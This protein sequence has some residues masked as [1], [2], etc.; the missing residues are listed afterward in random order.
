MELELVIVIVGSFITLG[1]SINAF[2]LRGISIDLNTVK[3]ELAK[4]IERSNA[5]EARIENLER[6]EREIFERLNIL[7]REVLK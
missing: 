7:E 1:L 6:S 2:F 3:I 5:K 4:M